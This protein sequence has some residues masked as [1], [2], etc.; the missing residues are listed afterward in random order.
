M[1]LEFRRNTVLKFYKLNIEDKSYFEKY[2]SEY[3]FNSCE[4]CFANL[5][6]WRN[7][8]EIEYAEFENCIIIKK[9]NFE[10][11]TY[12]MQPLGYKKDNLRVLVEQ[13]RG[14]KTEHN[15]DY[16]FA[17]LEKFFVDDLLNCYNNDL[18]ILEDRNNFDYI[19]NTKDLVNLSGKKLHNKKNHYNQFIKGYNYTL[20][21]LNEQTITDC[22]L[23]EKKWLENVNEKDNFL[24]HEYEGIKDLLINFDKLQLKGMAVCVEN[25]V[26]AFTIGEKINAK[27]AII[28]IE[29]ADPSYNGIYAFINKTFVEKYFNEVPSINR[30]QDL[31]KEGL[32][33]AKQSYKPFEFVE[34]YMVF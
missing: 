34:K 5:Y 10:G 28:H 3:E 33:K 8:C 11:K 15:M 20:K 6:L 29:K 22:L 24:N 30:E 21:A 25:K 9:K 14:Y 13:L 17:D 27:T 2:I 16:L 1:T 18:E 4:Y 32:I 12:F 23:L 7:A 31:G 19:Y 26:I